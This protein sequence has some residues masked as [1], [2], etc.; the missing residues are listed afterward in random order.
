MNSDNFR[1]FGLERIQEVNPLDSKF[2]KDD[3]FHPDRFF[4]YSIGISEM[5]ETPQIV[6]F[7]S[8][9][10]LSPYLRSQPLHHSQN[11]P[12]DN[13]FELEVLLTIELKNILLGCGASV[14]VL[15]PEQLRIAIQKDLNDA[16]SQYK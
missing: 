14:E 2:Q 9:S 12:E 15:Q 4:K 3:N 16:S 13:V 6:R 1:T 8:S 5:E 10:S 11:E 7:K